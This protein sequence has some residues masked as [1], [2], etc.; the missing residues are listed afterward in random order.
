MYG[1]RVY[2]RIR[3]AG[4]EKPAFDWDEANAAHLARHAVTPAEV[5]HILIGASL[6]LY[7]EERSGEERH[8]ELGETASGRL[9][10]VVWTW[11]RQKIRVVT[12]FPAERKWRSLW[13]RLRKGGPN[14]Q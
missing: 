2:T 7:T 5:E 11:R 8:I 1:Q 12:A 4:A 6:P 10:V 14:A 3:M 9:L 13:Q